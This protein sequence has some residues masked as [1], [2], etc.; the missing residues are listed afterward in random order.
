MPLCCPRK[1]NPT[2]D[3]TDKEVFIDIFE[4][5]ADKTVRIETETGR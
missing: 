1:E 5:N 3:I 4:S 2:S